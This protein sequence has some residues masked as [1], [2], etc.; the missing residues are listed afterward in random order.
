MPGMRDQWKQLMTYEQ[1][2][3][4]LLGRLLL[5]VVL[6]AIVD[7]LGTLAIYFAE[8]NAD[9]TEITS[10]GDALFFTTVQLLTVSSQLRNP[11]TTLGRIVDVFLELWAVIVVA[12]TAG[13]I[14]A[15]FQSAD[16]D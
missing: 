2:H 3:E 14:A 1:R 9:D 5:V 4:Q 13:A 11:F 12:G 8:R 7:V 10:L 6:T 16:P 15:F